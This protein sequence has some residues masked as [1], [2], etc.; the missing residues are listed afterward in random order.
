ME[1]LKHTNNNCNNCRAY[2]T[3][4]NSFT[5]KYSVKSSRSNNKMEGDERY[6]EFIKINKSYDHY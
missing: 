3:S 5:Y 4:H 6:N 2:K 1:Y